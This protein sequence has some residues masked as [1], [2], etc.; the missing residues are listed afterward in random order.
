M[1][2]SSCTH[3]I[4]M[5]GWGGDSRGWQPWARLAAG[6]GWSF[7]SG[8][9]GYGQLPPGMPSWEPEARRRVVLAHSMGPHLLPAKLLQQATTVVLLASFANFVP[10]GPAG[11][12]VRAA[13]RAMSQRL[14]AGEAGPLLSDFLQQVA[15]PHPASALPPGP[16]E[17][18][19]SPAGEQRLLEDLQQ[20]AQ[21]SA[22]PDGFP[23]GAAVL[24]VEANDDLIVHEAS[25]A[26]L[27]EAL[28]DAAVWS[29]SGA[30]HALLLPDLPA[31]VISWIGDAE[32]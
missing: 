4:A 29:L 22:L 5:H 9:R 23:S 15:A 21:T 17:Q 20:L 16:L 19:L 28:P 18:G 32:T 30:G 1:S 26:Q 3:L 11:R 13:L 12:S 7:S 2:S 8:E 31:R 14:Q 24:I 27:R 10:G 25:R 6:R